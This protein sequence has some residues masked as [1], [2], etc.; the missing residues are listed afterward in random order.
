[1]Q[2][3]QQPQNNPKNKS[4]FLV[5]SALYTKFGVYKHEERLQQTIDTCKSIRERCGDKVDILVLDGGEGRPNE[6]DQKLLGPHIDLVYF[7]GDSDNIKQLH[8]INSQDI[9]K[10][11]IE[12][13]M[14]GSFLNM[15]VNENWSE[16][17]DRVF[18]LSG[19]YK[20]T[21]DFDYDTHATDIGSIIIRGPFTSQFKPEITGGVTLQYMSRLWSFDSCLIPAISAV[22]QNMFNHMN[23]R[24]SEGGYIDI[25]HLLYHHLNRDL[26]KNISRIG[27]EGNIAPNGAGVRE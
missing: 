26:V 18:K 24:L 21:D 2:E 17:Y 4:L 13:I 22:Y 10:N 14:T 25:E 11:M 9:V 8:Q 6:E 23:Q 27:V 16:K 7:F 19:R 20:L 3:N 15:M 1:M 5:T 12:I